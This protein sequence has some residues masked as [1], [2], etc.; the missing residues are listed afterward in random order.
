MIGQIGVAR[1]RHDLEQ[2]AV[3]G[4]RDAIS[5]GG[6]G[7]GGMDVIGVHAGP[8][9]AQEG[10]IAVSAFGKPGGIRGQVPGDDV[11]ERT[12]G[13]GKAPKS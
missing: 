4:R 7:A 6:P 5:V 11:R 10:R 1:P 3:E 12:V 13:S 9:D 8:H 2:I